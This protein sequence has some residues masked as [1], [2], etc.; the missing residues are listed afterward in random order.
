MNEV[1][2]VNELFTDEIM[3]VY[4]RVNETFGVYDACL[5][6]EFK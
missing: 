3:R 4:Q 6:I 1:C 2:N 5:T